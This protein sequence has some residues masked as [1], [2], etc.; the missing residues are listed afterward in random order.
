LNADI[1]KRYI[2]LYRMAR[3]VLLHTH[4]P[5]HA[6]PLCEKNISTV[7]NAQG[8]MSAYYLAQGNMSRKQA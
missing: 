4:T 1:L 7:P 3:V 6:H 2:P 8:N 5:K